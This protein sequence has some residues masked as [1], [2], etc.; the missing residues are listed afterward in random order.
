MLNLSLATRLALR[1]LRHHRV[2][3]AATI[4]GVAIGMAVV[5]AVL[6]VDRNTVRTAEQQARLELRQSGKRTARTEE[7]ARPRE[8]LS[9]RVIRPGAPSIPP[10]LIPT[11]K[12]GA[13]GA[14][15]AEQASLGR[16]EDDYQAMRLAV[17]LASLFAFSIG[18]VLVF[19]TMRYSVASRSRAFSLLLCLGEFRSNIALSL[20]VESLLLGISGTVLGF[21]AGIPLARALLLMGVS[22]TGRKPLAGF[23]VPWGEMVLMALV[24]VTVALLGIIGPVRSLFRLQVSEVLHPRFLAEQSA[25]RKRGFLWI[26]PP[27]IVATYL[28]VRPFLQS[29]FSVVQF[30][31]FEAVFVVGLTIITLM[32]VQPLLRLVLYG[33]DL[34]LRPIFPLET[35]LIG[36]RMRL[37][38]NNTASSIIGI[39]VVFALLTGLH[40]VTRSL[41]SEISDWV[42]TATKGY[43]FFHVNNFTPAEVMAVR[44]EM[45]RRGFQVFRLSRTLPGEFPL[46]LIAAE[47]VNPWRTARGRPPIRPGAVIFSKTLA[48]RFAV[49]VGDA[50]E[51]TGPRESHRFDV[52]EIADDF[53]YFVQRSSYV[54]EKTYAIFS[55]GNPLFADLERTL[56]EFAVAPVGSAPLPV[57]RAAG[58]HFDSYYLGMNGLNDYRVG[59]I[60]RDFLI[61]DFVMLMTIILAAVGVTNTLLIQVHA[62]SRE[63]SVL[64]TVGISRGQ[65]SKLLLFE[66]GIIGLLSAML[67]L[68]LGHALGLISVTFLDRFTLF[69]YAFAFSIRDSLAIYAFTVVTCCIAA[70]YPASVATR[71]A[72]AESLHYE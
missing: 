25:G 4:L 42:K 16:G 56:G 23:D 47:D 3:G 64:T 29:W 21:L 63:F 33:F 20:L 30:F 15:I 67:A 62:R 58:K 52:I 57:A 32:W 35:L 10:S 48:A 68:I 14:K 44:A 18:T 27:L 40:D 34:I 53:G 41:K 70:I 8:V 1:N 51:I 26:V 71:P 6:I 69:E 11:Q 60:D 66:G 17:R 72:T 54:D 5:S 61:F 65:L 45:R 39:T 50:I 7:A 43:M 38:S 55:D 2:V 9:V 28:L 46:R 36:R 37:T 24:S 31:I 13:S 22:T 49:A 59:E 12:S 19:Y